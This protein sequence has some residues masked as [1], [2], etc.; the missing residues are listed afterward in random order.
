MKVRRGE[1]VRKSEILAAALEL[2]HEIGYQKITRDALAIKSC[3][4]TGLITTYFGTMNHFRR[5]IISHAIA[6]HDLQVIAQGLTANEAKAHNASEDL[7]R[8]AME[9]TLM[10]VQE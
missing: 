6:R 1:E 2:A 4:S 10:M 9:H 8:A 3:C 5:A 7:K